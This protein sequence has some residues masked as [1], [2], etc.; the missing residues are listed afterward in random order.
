[1]VAVRHLVPILTEMAGVL[2]WITV[3][4]MFIAGFASLWEVIFKN[5]GTHRDVKE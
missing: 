3:V 1:L 2:D 5:K 4:A